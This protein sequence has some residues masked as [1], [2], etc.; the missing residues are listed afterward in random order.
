MP[1]DAPLLIVGGSTRAAAHSALRAGRRP[2]CADAFAD[3]DLRRIATVYPLADYPRGVPR[4]LRDVP[5]MPWLY[6]GGLENRPR[7]LESLARRRP[8]VGNS[9]DVVRAVRDPVRLTA[10]LQEAGLPALDVRSLDDPP[11]P[12]GTWLRK[13]LRSG[14]GLGVALWDETEN[15]PAARAHGGHWFQR[16]ARGK[17]VSMMFIAGA[18]VTAFGACRHIEDRRGLHAGPFGWC[19]AI[20]PVEL[21]PRVA[22]VMRQVGEFL[23]QRFTLRGLFGIDFITDGQTA[24]PLEV[25]PRFTATVELLEAAHGRS[26]LAEHLRAFGETADAWNPRRPP[27]RL[28][29]KAIVYTPRPL[30]VPP[31]SGLDPTLFPEPTDPR[32]LPTVADI[33]QAGALVPTA[34]PVC[35]ILATGPDE[36]TTFQTLRERLRALGEHFGL[37]A[38]EAWSFTGGMTKVQ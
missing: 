16:R 36:P 31:W 38:A 11:L 17:A 33:P 13:P 12:D 2:H 15:A 14:G 18:D 27:D 22:D 6:T 26:L 5:P 28:A 9:A 29:A 19:G 24:W 4:A 1:G 3:E 23:A 32:E 30:L 10:A 35:T 37:S 34:A 8:L 20:G 21:P 25:N 7:L